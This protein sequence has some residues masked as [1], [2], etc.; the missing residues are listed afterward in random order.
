MIPDSQ[1]KIWPKVPRGCRP[2]Y[3]FQLPREEVRERS[4]IVMFRIKRKKN[5]QSFIKFLY[6]IL[7]PFIFI[8]IRIMILRESKVDKREVS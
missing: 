5:F 2:C 4:V 8:P 3:R 6:T 1:Y 7:C